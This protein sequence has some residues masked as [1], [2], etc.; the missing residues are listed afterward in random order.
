MTPTGTAVV[1]GSEFRVRAEDA[2]F[3]ELTQVGLVFGSTQLP[4]GFGLV[5]KANAPVLPPE[6]LLPPT[7]FASSSVPGSAPLQVARHAVPGATGYRAL[8]FRTGATTE[9]LSVS[10]ALEAALD[11]SP[12]GPGRYQG[13]VRAVA[14]SGL[15]SKDAR[16][17]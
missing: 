1:R 15:E 13:L 2:Q 11:L 16:S 6:S 8:L 12:P 7:H 14:P 10:D 3:V 9:L 17:S 4:S 5:S